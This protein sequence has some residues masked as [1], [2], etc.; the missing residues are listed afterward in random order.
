[1]GRLVIWGAGELGG[2]VALLWRRGHRGEV[3]GVLRGA[4]REDDL[5]GAGVEPTRE[6]PPDFIQPD[7]LLVLALPGSLKQR[8]AVMTL[9]VV[10]PPRRSILIS[11][12]AVY[13]SAAGRVDEDTPLGG[14]ERAEA[15]VRAES[16]FR[17]W[18]GSSGVILRFGGLHRPGR[19]PIGALR[20]NGVAHPGPPNRALPLIHYDDAAQAVFGALSI[21]DPE[22]VYLGV[23]PPSPTRAAF[24]QRA[25][26]VLGLPDPTFTEPLPHEPATFDVSRLRRDLLPTPAQPDWRA[27]ATL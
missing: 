19:G 8:A 1:M 21:R 24:Y 22:P 13:G 10:K 25:C 2:R 20:R 3:I 17:E 26:A 5:R 4:A 6:L 11:S 18:A 23:T 16:D 12:T 27:A 15:A 9:E 7:D 14:G